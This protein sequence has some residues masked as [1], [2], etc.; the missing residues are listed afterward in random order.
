MNKRKIDALFGELFSDDPE[1]LIV[2]K[3][4]IGNDLRFFVVARESDLRGFFGTGTP[5]GTSKEALDD[6]EKN[7]LAVRESSERYEKFKIDWN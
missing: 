5:F 7:V 1:I 6:F 3:K 4:P 2:A